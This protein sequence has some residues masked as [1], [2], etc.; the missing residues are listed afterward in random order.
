MA[1]AF[2]MT[3]ASVTIFVE[4]IEVDRKYYSKIFY[5]FLKD[6]GITAKFRA[7]YEL[8]SEG[9]PGLVNAF[10][11]FFDNDRL[12]GKSGD[13][14]YTVVFCMD[15]DIDDF[16]NRKIDSKHVIYT[17]YFQVE[18]H[19]IAESDFVEA[20]ASTLSISSDDLPTLLIE[21]PAQWL[22]S[23]AVIWKQ[24]IAMCITCAKLGQQQANYKRPSQ[25]NDG[26]LGPVVE[27]KVD[28][29]LQQVSQ[30]EGVT[31]Q[32]C[33]A[34]FAD[35]LQHVDTL[36]SSD[37]Y[38]NVFRGKWYGLLIAEYL[39]IEATMPRCSY[40]GFEMKFWSALL[41]GQNPACASCAGFK[42][43]LAIA[44]SRQ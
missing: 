30:R 8:G 23:L 7:S 43:A 44:L 2:L 9:K 36:F 5:E 40:Q 34:M 16:L 13:Q 20:L 11:Y 32:E 25:I 6:E 17:E 22:K 39:K 42:N 29:Y 21:N 33:R 12:S 41:M 26:Y 28:E 10:Q 37:A 4:G 15:K 18:N 38:N 3:S 24:W 27:E 1:R 31:L 14:T 19:L 35:S